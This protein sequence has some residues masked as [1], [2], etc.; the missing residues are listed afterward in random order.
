MEFVKI[1]KILNTHGVKGELK[2]D[3]YTDFLDERFKKDS[4]IYIGKEYKAY[5]VESYRFHN[6]FMLL[7]L[8]GIL[9]VD[10]VIKLKNSYIY[11]STDDIKPLEDG[12]YF[13][14]LKNLDVYMED[15]L[16]GKVLYAESG[17]AS[18]YLRVLSLN[19]KE[20]LVPILDPFI[21]NVDMQ[22][23]RVN[24]KKVEGLF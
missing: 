17:I 18:N 3:V 15:K 19:S 5:K 12:F 11:K 13:R 6:N 8:G 16:V 9:N 4:L 23:N 20:V 2:V 10:E 7:T 21:L 24:L 14:D 22:N 1:A